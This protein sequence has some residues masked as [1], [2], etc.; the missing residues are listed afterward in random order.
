MSEVSFH[1]REIPEVVKKEKFQVAD[2][3]QVIDKIVSMP[4]DQRDSVTLNGIHYTPNQ[5]ITEVKLS[6]GDVVPIETAI[7]LAEN[8]MLNGYSTGMTFKGGRT[9]RAK[10]DPEGSINSIH[11]LPQF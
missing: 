7:A 2:S 1:G 9:L 4:K 10:P 11:S 5:G 3:R 6:T 8:Y